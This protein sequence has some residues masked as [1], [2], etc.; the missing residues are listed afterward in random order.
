M[1]G[2]M[3]CGKWFLLAWLPMA[4][5]AAGGCEGTDTREGVDDTVA[6]VVGKKDVERYRQMKDEIGNIQTLQADRYRRLD[7]EQNK[8]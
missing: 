7:Q 3:K 8:Q 4:V 2:W 1:H 6:E 5:M